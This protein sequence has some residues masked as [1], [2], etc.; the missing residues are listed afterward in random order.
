MAKFKY[1]KKENISSLP[2]K[3]GVYAFSKRKKFLY[4]GKAGK[5]KNRVRN[6]FSQPV[7][8]DTLFTK[9]TDRIGYIETDSEI[10]ALILEAELIKKHKPKFNILWKDDKNYF[11]AGVTK[12]EFPRVFITHRPQLSTTN[13][14]LQ[15]NYIGP[16]VDGRALKDSLKALRKVFPYRSCKRIPKKPCLWYQLKLCPGPCTLKTKLADQIPNFKEKVKK[17]SQENTQNLIKVLE[18]KKFQ[19]VKNLK[20][21]MK[22]ASLQEKFERAGKLRDKI[23]ALEN[24]LEHSQIFKD[25]QKKREINWPEAKKTL[26]KVLGIKKNIIRIEGYD[27]SNISGKEA[28][29]SMVVFGKGKPQKSKYRKFKIKMEQKPND[30]AMIGEVLKRRLRHKE[31]SYPQVILID[32]GRGQFNTAVSSKAQNSK[33]KSIKV[34]AL[35]KKKNE[36]F[37]E[38]KKP[39]FLE[40]LPSNF[41]SLIL[42]IRDES[43]RFALKYHKILR[44]KKIRS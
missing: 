9:E 34:M 4:I 21:E 17:E 20:K 8:K 11:Y 18:G 29:G 7:F 14:K 6:H 35:A 22:E 12:E 27:I 15:T 5:I 40:S 25:W 1:F 23:E 41:S 39:I 19:A 32:G 38:N 24:I 30:T 44:R 28:V 13:Y 2:Q 3:P 33:S 31:W 16:F 36:L 10:E 37:L 42:Q 26:R 43:H